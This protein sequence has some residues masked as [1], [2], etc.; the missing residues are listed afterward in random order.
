M[1]VTQR[2]CAQCGK[3][4]DR[5]GSFCSHCGNRLDADPA[6][7]P[8][9]PIQVSQQPAA[10]PVTVAK[11]THPILTFIGGT[12]VVLI[13][14]GVA[15]NMLDKN[16]SAVRFVATDVLTDD[17]CTVMGDY[18]LRVHCTFQNSGSAAGE[19]NVRAQLISEP[20][21]KIVGDQ[22]SRLTLMENATQRVTFNFP[23]ATIDMKAKARC[24]VD[25]R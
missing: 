25:E 22:T 20:D 10:A 6:S 23:E 9:P 19:R 24:S 18:C 4:T 1:A 16:A 12:V 7:P 11:N 13:I 5:N 17:N 2:F 14:V 15:A 21:A 8:V 3:Q